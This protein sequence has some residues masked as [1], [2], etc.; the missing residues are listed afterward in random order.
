[1]DVNIGE[2]NKRISIVSIEVTNN[3]NGFE[4]EQEVEYLNCWC[5][6]SNMSGTEIFK[7]NADYS[8]VITRFLIRYR[9]DKIITTDMKVKFGK[10]IVNGEEK[11]IYYNITYA[12]NYNYS[13]EFLELIGEVVENG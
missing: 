1:M 13:N 7:A 6:V 11:D 9:K 12:N 3:E 2:L 5:K 8:K 4:V 10:K